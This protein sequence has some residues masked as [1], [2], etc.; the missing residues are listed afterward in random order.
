MG[1]KIIDKT[2]DTLSDVELI[3]NYIKLINEP[4]IICKNE[5]IRVRSKNFE[6]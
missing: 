5:I 3:G 4:A 2:R 1:M 6:Q